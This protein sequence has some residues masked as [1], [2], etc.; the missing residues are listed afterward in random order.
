M[1]GLAINRVAKNVDFGHKKGED[2]GKWPWAAHPFPSSLEV[3]V[4]CGPFR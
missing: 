1:F 3:P 2:F 4:P